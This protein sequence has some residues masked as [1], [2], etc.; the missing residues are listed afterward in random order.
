[1]MQ[2]VVRLTKQ[3]R[4]TLMVRNLN[5][6]YAAS[7]VTN[8]NTPQDTNSLED[9][10]RKFRSWVKKTFQNKQ[11]EYYDR[12]K[13]HDSA[14]LKDEDQQDLHDKNIDSHV[15]KAS[16]STNSSSA[17]SGAS[18]QGVKEGAGSEEWESVD[19]HMKYPNPSPPGTHI[20]NT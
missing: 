6:R 1:M 20:K 9:T 10:A 17:S 12:L 4:G 19:G 5:Q 11:E 15:D 18:K 14:Y 8:D 7:T 2:R 3:Q 13:D 16:S